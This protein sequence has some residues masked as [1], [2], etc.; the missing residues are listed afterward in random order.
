MNGH[1]RFRLASPTGARA[2]LLLLA[3]ALLA[4]NL[5]AGATSVG[6]V[7][8]EIK[9]ALPLSDV[10]AG[11]LTALPG[12]VFAVAG[13]SA[14][15]V[16]RRMGLHRSLAAL[17]LAV[18][19]GLAVRPY[20]PT[21]LFFVATILALS[22]MA[23]G[24][25]LAPVFVKRHFPN[26][27]GSVMAVYTVCLAIG[28]A[29]P[30]A[31]AQPLATVLP[32]G[33]RT[34]LAFWSLFAF[35]AMVAMVVVI[36]V[37]AGGT[38]L[39]LRGGMGSVAAVARSPKAWWI[40][41]FFGLQSM[42][43]YIHF[44]WAPQIYRDAGMDP[45]AAGWMLTIITSLG[46]PG[47]FIVPPLLMRMRRPQVLVI[48]LAALLAVGY[49][50][51]LWAPLTL[52][53]LWALCLG[54]SGFCFPLALTLISAR[55]RDLDITT[56]LSAFS[57]SLGYVMAGAGPLLI[58]VL[59]ELTGGWRI[60][61]LVLLVGSVLLGIAGVLACRPGDVD[62]DVLRNTPAGG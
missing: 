61:L 1:S 43:A 6:P 3:I 4:M 18:G 55:A 62:D 33:W 54:V 11:I 23:I 10:G 24:N 26:R 40:G 15:G 50:G 37:G 29:V 60:P 32:G 2:W 13:L 41:I 45:V 7:L 16:A 19:V 17:L 42:N 30:T 28:A 27:I 14:A 57:Q 49:A 53:W 59:V 25:V 52:P 31:A 12:F 22:G 9:E 36:V 58:G 56:G 44:G 39:R 34:S 48:G 38:G 21:W 5:R 51:L 35:A 8:G 47:G 46:I 20:V